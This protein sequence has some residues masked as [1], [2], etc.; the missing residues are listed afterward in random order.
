MEDIFGKDTNLQKTN[1]SYLGGLVKA[2]LYF[3]N[4]FSS[5]KPSTIG[6]IIFN[7][8]QYVNCCC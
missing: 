7:L 5:Y 6:A 3:G 1:V 2:Y 8:I 4:F